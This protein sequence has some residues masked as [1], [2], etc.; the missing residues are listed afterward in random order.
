MSKLPIF[1]QFFSVG[2]LKPKFKW[3]LKLKLKPKNVLLNWVPVVAAAAAVA[4]TAALHVG[5]GRELLSQFGAG[6]G[7]D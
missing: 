4:G 6:Y 2:N 7:L 1:K 5:V 3:F